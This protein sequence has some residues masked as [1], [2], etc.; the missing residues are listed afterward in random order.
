M[1]NVMLPV[2]AAAIARTGDVQLQDAFLLTGPI[3]SIIRNCQ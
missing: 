2:R 1:P 3:H